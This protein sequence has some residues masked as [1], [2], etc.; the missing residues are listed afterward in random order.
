MNGMLID[1]QELESAVAVFS[2][3]GSAKRLQI[4]FC[5]EKGEK[6]VS[7]L[8]E[9]ISCRQS[10]TSQQLAILK[11]SGIVTARRE[12]HEMFYRITRPCVLSFLSCLI[13][14]ECGS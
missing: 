3:L 13:N 5:L 2:A 14:K 8:S 12:G 11:N 6:S 10:C 4:V 1:E 9:L 7:E